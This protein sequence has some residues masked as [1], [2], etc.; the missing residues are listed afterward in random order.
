MFVSTVWSYQ[1]IILKLNSN[2]ILNGSSS[3]KLQ[4]TFRI[5]DQTLH[6][7]LS[8]FVSKTHNSTIHGNIFTV[9]DFA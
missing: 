3:L 9:Y 7:V 6:V 5:L 1:F 2:E 8:A 4:F